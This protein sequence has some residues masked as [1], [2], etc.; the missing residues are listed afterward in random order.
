MNDH[1]HPIS[2]YSWSILVDIHAK[3]GDFEGCARIIDEM[4]SEGVPPTQAAYT[5][6]MAA[7]YKVCND[8]RIPH[9][10]RAKAGKLGWNKWQEMRVVGIEPDAMAYGAIIRLCAARGRP[11]RAINLL[12][13]M[14]RFEVKPTTLCFSSALRAVA[15]SHEIAVR[16]ERGWSKKQLR[17]ESFAAHHGK[18]AR[19]IVIL[20][21]VAEAEQDEGFV[22]ALMLCAAAAGDSATAKA[23][24][25]AAEVR[26]MDH[27]RTIGPESHL[28]QL[29]GETTT[30]PDDYADA[31]L[32]A[33]TNGVANPV[34]EGSIPGETAEESHAL[35]TTAGQSLAQQND[36]AP[37]ARHRHDVVKSFGEREYG[38]DTRALSAMLRACA[39]AMDSNGIGTIWAGKQNLGYLCE[40]SLR[41]ITT[42]W[43]PSYRDTSVPGVS[44]TKFGIGNLRK[45]DQDERDNEKI[46]KRKKFRGLYL[47]EDAEDAIDDLKGHFE[48]SFGDDDS[49]T[50]DEM[51]TP[52][53]PGSLAFDE[54]DVSRGSDIDAKDEIVYDSPTLFEVPDETAESAARSKLGMADNDFELYQVRSDGQIQCMPSRLSFT[55]GRTIYARG[56][57]LTVA[58]PYSLS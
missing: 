14:Q 19:S 51:E 12:E 33:L 29:R 9:A 55:R 48:D 3:L 47:D 53:R 32:Q 41:L 26:K 16:F 44:P 37:Q 23:V 49:E 35:A 7:C 17:R 20:A 52:P 50:F 15:K 36:H 34:S 40:N 58:S 27:L 56:F 11:E 38:H 24:Y 31:N 8:G 42:R 43:E 30:M 25:L 21:E 39:Q 2:A 6:L 45:Y 22:S 4:A 13:D 57:G 18:M 28:R 54:Y 46:G 10:L 1:Q 5:S